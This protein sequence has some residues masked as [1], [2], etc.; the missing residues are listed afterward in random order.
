MAVMFANRGLYS[1]LSV[2]ISGSTDLRQAVFKGTPPNA[3]TV[4]DYNFLSDVTGAHTEAAAS[5]YVRADLAG[6]TLAENDTPNN[7][8][9]V[10]DAPTYTA[11]AAGET[12]TFVAY[13]I[14]NASDSAAVLICI[15]DPAA[16][17]VTNGGNI[18]GPALSVTI[19]DV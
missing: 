18:V 11:V 3:A 16:D 9:L 13:Y 2:A 4:A 19:D 15:D 7:A 1:L 5:G 8:T 12:W 17:Q 6:V 14:Y 10:A